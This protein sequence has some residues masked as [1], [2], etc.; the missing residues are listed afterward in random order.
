MDM[1]G[2]HMNSLKSTMG[3]SV[4]QFHL[5]GQNE[6]LDELKDWIRFNQT[7]TMK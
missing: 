2:N 7:E 1:F 3:I 4:P 5:N 6:D